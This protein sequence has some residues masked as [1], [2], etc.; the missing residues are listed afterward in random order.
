L[1]KIASQIDVT[2]SK[3]ISKV[4]TK[5]DNEFGTS[6]FDALGSD[7]EAEETT[8]EKSARLHRKRVQFLQQQHAGKVARSAVRKMLKI[9]NDP[10]LTANG[11][12]KE[13][14]QCRKDV[15]SKY[16]LH[17]KQIKVQDK[18][19]VDRTAIWIEDLDNYLRQILDREGIPE[20]AVEDNRI[21]IRLGGDGRS[22]HRNSNNVLIILALMDHR[23]PSKSHLDDSVH[24]LMLIDGGESHELLLTS[25]SVIDDWI[26]KLTAQKNSNDGSEPWGL[27]Y[28]VFMDTTSLRFTFRLLK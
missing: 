15:T 2:L 21:T 28:K 27:V 14:K 17:F 12:E 8:E 13:W 11:L 6:F 3:E 7:D 4:F 22:I 23:N 1:V 19:G 16:N 5:L 25:L 18:K 24:T 9:V 10:D 20:S 26:K